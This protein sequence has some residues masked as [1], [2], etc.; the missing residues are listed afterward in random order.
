[1][2]IFNHRYYLDAFLADYRLGNFINNSV[3]KVY[4][5]MEEGGCYR[6][7]GIHKLTPD[8]NRGKH[9]LYLDVVNIHGIRDRQQID[10]GWVGQRRT[11]VV[12]PVVLD[13]PLDEPAGNISIGGGQVIW[14]KVLNR[15]SDMILN[16]TTG[17]PDESPGNTWGHH[18][19]YTVW[20]WEE[21]RPGL[22]PVE[23]PAPPSH[24]AYEQGVLDGQNRVATRVME[25]LREFI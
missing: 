20:V 6:L 23:P 17:L 22:P 19:Y 5:T 16:V 24:S 25:A 4:R 14:A 10:W 18:S 12:Q 15:N 9:N 13:K 21:D 1:M 11:E 7:I 3:A 2:T 8:E